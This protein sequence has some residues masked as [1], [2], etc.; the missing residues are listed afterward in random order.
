M[1]AARWRRYT[2]ING[3][4][5]A[6][7]LRDQFARAATTA[8]RRRPA[9][10]M[11]DAG[12]LHGAPP[13][14]NRRAAGGCLVPCLESWACENPD[15][16]NGHFTRPFRKVKRLFFSFMSF[17]VTTPTEKSKPR[18]LDCL[19]GKYNQSRKQVFFES[20]P[21]MCAIFRTLSFFASEA[22]P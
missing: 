13:C 2:A 5:P 16:H 1:S 14:G 22:A 12:G 7:R 9:F 3:K 19:C 21:Q 6:P 8:D 15:G 20:C 4:A 18:M 11:W 17:F 10:F